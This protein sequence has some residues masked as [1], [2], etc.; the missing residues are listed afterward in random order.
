MLYNMA[1]STTSSFYNVCNEAR[2][3]RSIPLLAAGK[4]WV[5]GCPRRDNARRV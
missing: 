4:I 5:S 2:L 1:T 3:S